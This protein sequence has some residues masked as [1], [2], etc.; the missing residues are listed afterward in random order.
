MVKG[1]FAVLCI[2]CL[3]NHSFIKSFKNMTNDS[4]YHI[5]N[6]DVKGYDHSDAI[7]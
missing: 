5:E 1:P 3:Q 6:K 4:W 7:M 2:V